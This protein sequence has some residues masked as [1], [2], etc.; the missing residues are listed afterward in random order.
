MQMEPK[1]FACDEALCKQGDD[2]DC[3]F[4]LV[5]GTAKCMVMFDGV[6][7]QEVHRFNPFDVF[8]ERCVMKVYFPFFL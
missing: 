6:G 4:V 1:E 2:A 5:E 3:L 7:E 8:G